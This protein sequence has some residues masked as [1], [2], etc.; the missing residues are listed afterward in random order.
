MNTELRETS[1]VQAARARAKQAASLQHRLSLQGS[2]ARLRASLHRAVHPKLQ[3]S[4]CKSHGNGRSYGKLLD[5]R[6]KLE[7]RTRAVKICW[8]R[9]GLCFQTFDFNLFH[10]ADLS[11]L[12]LK[13]FLFHSRDWK[14]FL[15][16]QY[17]NLTGRW[18]LNSYLKN[19]VHL[20]WRT[21]VSV[22]VHFCFGN[23]NLG[24]QILLKQWGKYWKVFP[25]Q[26]HSVPLV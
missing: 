25:C 16:H 23:P 20:Y 21:Y 8:V 17:A 12:F 10:S 9:E 22:H 18:A 6:A 5:W 19:T 13:D 24:L 3:G 1:R 11:A 14:P 2:S 15:W 7:E 26:F 4:F